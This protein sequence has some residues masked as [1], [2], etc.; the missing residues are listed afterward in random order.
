MELSQEVLMLTQ[1][2][3][4]GTSESTL[5]QVMACCLMTPSHYLN[6]C[7]L[8]IDKVQRHLSGGHFKEDTSATVHYNYHKHYFC[9]ISFQ[10]PSGQWVK[11][12]DACISV[13]STSNDNITYTEGCHRDIP[14]KWLQV[15]CICRTELLMS[16]DTSGNVAQGSD[17]RCPVGRVAR[18]GNNSKYDLWTNPKKLSTSASVQLTCIK[19]LV[20]YNI[21]T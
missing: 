3:P 16:R 5:A 10:S 7:W 13:L 19:C 20:Y 1:C 11:V 8:I 14:G 9:I 4:V 2:G 21:N 18:N 12:W 15:I 6:Q 17:R